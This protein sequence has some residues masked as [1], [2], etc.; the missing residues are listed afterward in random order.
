[1]TSIDHAGIQ[2]L[3]ASPQ[4]LDAV[5]EAGQAVKH[6]AKTIAPV[7]TGLYRYSLDVSL[8]G[9]KVVVSSYVPYAMSVEARHGTLAQ[10]LAMTAMGVRTIAAER[11]VLVRP[12]FY[13]G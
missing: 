1:M 5:I 6:N 12:V 9:N 10:A 7:D 8:D 11:P 2:A 3:L 4:V 13:D